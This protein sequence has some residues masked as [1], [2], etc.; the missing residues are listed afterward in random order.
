MK[1]TQ[2]TQT[3]NPTDAFTREQ[4]LRFAFTDALTALPNRRALALGARA[5]GAGRRSW[6]AIDLDGFKRAQDQEG[7]GHAWGDGALRS[8]A[9]HLRQVVRKSGTFQLSRIGGDEFVAVCDHPKAAA[10]VAAH[11]RAW[12]YSEVSASAGVGRTRRAADLALYTAKAAR[13]ATR[14][15]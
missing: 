2:P 11:A 12:R 15:A 4:L 3:L 14:A 13:R 9:A 5:I 1:N 10:R 6:V 8:F 7:R